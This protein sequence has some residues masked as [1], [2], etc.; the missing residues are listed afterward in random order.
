MP[1]KRKNNPNTSSFEVNINSPKETR[2]R[3]KKTYEQDDEEEEEAELIHK[4]NLN[5]GLTLQQSEI[6]CNIIKKPYKIIQVNWEQ[7]EEEDTTDPNYCFL[8]EMSQSTSEANAN[9]NYVKLKRFIN[10]N[11]PFMEPGILCR[12][13]QLIYN[14]TL[15]PHDKL[16]RNLPWS[17][18]MIWDHI[19]THTYNPV[20]CEE[21]SF[22]VMNTCLR[23]IRE[24]GLITT[25]T[26]TETGETWEDVDSGKLKMYLELYKERKTLLKTIAQRR[27]QTVL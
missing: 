22:R 14:N 1:P 13:A 11:Y 8:C 27:P 26:N 3:T 18:K 21:D 6:E 25:T 7:Y 15:R 23:V 24:N 19:E 9:V 4:H 2:K 5:E 12:Q 10:E 16:K 20:I 17:C